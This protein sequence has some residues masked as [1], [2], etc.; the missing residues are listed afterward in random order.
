MTLEDVSEEFDLV[1]AHV[2]SPSFYSVSCW[3]IPIVV[4]EH[5]S[6]IELVIAQNSKSTVIDALKGTRF[7][8][9]SNSLKER[10]IRSLGEE[11]RSNIEVVPNIVKIN[12]SQ[13]TDRNTLGAK[14]IYVGSLKDGKNVDLALHAFSHF[15]K[16]KPSSKFLIIGDGPRREELLSL[17]QNLQISESVEFIGSVRPEDVGPYLSESDLFVHLS[18]SETFGIATVEAILNKLPVVSLRNS[19]AEEAWGAIEKKV[20][21]LLPLYSSPPQIAQAVSELCSRRHSLEMAAGARWVKNRYSKE[22]IAATLLRIYAEEVD[23]ASS[24][25]S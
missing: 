22:V 3:P 13:A 24:P 10:I 9:V 7:L 1:H 18:E 6:K 25:R 5:Y 4:T 20:G 14:W 11:F 17:V 15:L 23:G 16:E 12:N 21:V 8:T 2:V 19:G